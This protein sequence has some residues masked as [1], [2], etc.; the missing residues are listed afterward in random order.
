MT[1]GTRFQLF[2]CKENRS[3]DRD[4]TGVTWHSHQIELLFSAEV[5]Q[6]EYNRAVWWEMAG[7]HGPCENNL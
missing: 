7:P 1:L 6:K 2:V 3:D 5:E 4:S